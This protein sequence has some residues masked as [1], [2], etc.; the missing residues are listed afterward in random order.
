MNRSSNNNNN[1]SSQRQEKD[2]SDLLDFQAMYSP[3]VTGQQQ[4]STTSTATTAT[5]NTTS[6]NPPTSTTTPN[7]T[8]NYTQADYYSNYS[9]S[10][11]TNQAVSAYHQF[12]P[13][14]QV[15]NSH[16]LH[17]QTQSADLLYQNGLMPGNDYWQAHHQAPY[18]DDQVY[19]NSDSHYLHAAAAAAAVATAQQ[20][21]P[22]LESLMTSSRYPKSQNNL[23]LNSS[24]PN[25]ATSNLTTAQSTSQSSLYPNENLLSAHVLPPGL[26]STSNPSLNTWTQDPTVAYADAPLP[27]LAY[28]TDPTYA[29]STSSSTSTSSVTNVSSN[30]VDK[31]KSIQSKV[32]TSSA[33]S[34]NEDEDDDNDD[35]NLSLPNKQSIMYPTN[36]NQNL[37]NPTTPIPIPSPSTG[38]SIPPNWQSGQGYSIPNGQLPQTSSG[39]MLTPNKNKN[40][41]NASKNLIAP[42]SSVENSPIDESETPEEREAREKERRA[43]NNA[44][45]R[46]RVRDINEAFKELGKMCGI[47]LRS[48]KPQT[49]LSILQQAVNVITSL[50]QQVRERNLNPKA[51]CLKRR[52]E[53]KTEDL[54]QPISLN[55]TPSG[56]SSNGPVG[57]SCL[58][59]GLSNSGANNPGLIGMQGQANTQMD[60][61]W[62]SR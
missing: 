20:S 23:M 54:N 19:Y 15:V 28:P 50:E 51:A 16:L 46:L 13:H 48:D 44:R 55:L 38:T 26:H 39:I 40:I 4:S 24:M 62:M 61:W 21:Q 25:L 45:E 2:L 27:H 58:N 35:K 33:S 60:N 30:L 6:T 53:E 41:K 10:Y 11:S 34:T 3:T 36:L 1:T 9:N 56:I 52:E 59:D 17:D 12:H 57:S 22:G 18:Y 29:S 49:K 5:T 37:S 42:P 7:T 14:G 43:A 47:H 31:K 8:T 32:K